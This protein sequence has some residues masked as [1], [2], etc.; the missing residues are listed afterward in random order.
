MSVVDLANTSRDNADDIHHSVPPGRDHKC[1]YCGGLI[2][3]VA[4]LWDG[5]AG[6]ILLHAGCAKGLALMLAKDGFNAGQI[7][8]G[9]QVTVGIVPSLR[10]P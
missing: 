1:F 2:T 4:V 10:A 9:R 6:E 7:E 5:A 8:R 3:H